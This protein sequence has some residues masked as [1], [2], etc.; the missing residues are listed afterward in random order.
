MFIDV[1]VVAAHT[2]SHTRSEEDA[3]VEVLLAHN[4]DTEEQRD[5]DVVFLYVNVLLD[6]I[7]HIF[8]RGR[9]ERVQHFRLEVE[10]F[11]CTQKDAGI[12][13]RLQVAFG[14]VVAEINAGFYA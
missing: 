6:F 13:S 14:D 3:E 11:S 12:R 8:E 2:Q 7:H 5:V 10:S 4:L 9:A 1:A